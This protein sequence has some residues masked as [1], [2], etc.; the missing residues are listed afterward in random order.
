MGY[1][2]Y[3]YPVLSGSC[4]NN[5]LGHYLYGT[6]NGNDIFKNIIDKKRDQIEDI[7]KYWTSILIICKYVFRIFRPIMK[8][9]KKLI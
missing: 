4:S 2:Y 6:D 1:I 7:L 9:H 8:L 5:V 3:L